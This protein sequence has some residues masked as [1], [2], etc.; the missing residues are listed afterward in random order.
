M[1]TYAKKK[2]MWLC[3][4]IIGIGSSSHGGRPSAQVLYNTYNTYAWDWR[5]GGRLHGCKIPTAKR[6][7]RRNFMYVLV[8]I[9]FD[10]LIHTLEKHNMTSTRV[11]QRLRRGHIR[12]SKSLIVVEYLFVAIACYVWIYDTYIHTI[13]PPLSYLGPRLYTTGR[14]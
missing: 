4:G 11:S 8:S 12:F 10:Y 13:F 9:V 14:S 6:S 3:G 2:K 1:Y 5:C 7:G